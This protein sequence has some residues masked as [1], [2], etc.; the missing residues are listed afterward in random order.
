MMYME[1]IR[2]DPA[3]SILMVRCLDMDSHPEGAVDYGSR[4]EATTRQ[5]VYTLQGPWMELGRPPDVMGDLYH[6]GC[7]VVGFRR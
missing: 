2:P 3:L 6:W 1:T 5:G 7:R 4:F